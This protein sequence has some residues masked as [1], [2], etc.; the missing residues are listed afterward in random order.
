MQV[1]EL[2]DEQGQHQQYMM[3]WECEKVANG[4]VVES[5]EVLPEVTLTVPHDRLK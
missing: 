4:N 3:T 1:R 5:E 2:T